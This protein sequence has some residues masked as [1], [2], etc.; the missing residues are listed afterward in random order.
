MRRVA[1]VCAVGMLGVGFAGCPASR[2]SGWK[3][4]PYPDAHDFA[5]T[6]VH[7]ADSAYSQRLA[8]LLDT[9]DA[10]DMKVTLTVFAFWAD[11]ASDGK[12]WDEWRSGSDTQ[13][14]LAP[15]GVPLV[16][17]DEAAFY[18]HAAARG[19]E[20]GL[21]T[22]SDTSDTREDVKRAFELYE[23]VFGHPLRMYVEHSQSSNL[24]DQFHD[25]SKPG[26]PYYCTDLLKQYGPWVWLDGPTG[27]PPERQPFY[28]LLAANGTPFDETAVERFGISRAFVRSGRWSDADGSGFLESYSVDNIDAL[29][30]ERGVALVYTHLDDRWLDPQTRKTREDIVQRLKYLASKDGWFVPAGA[31]LDRF[32]AMKSVTL[33]SAGTVVSIHNAG[34]ASVP[35]VTIINPRKQTLYRGSEALVA[36]AQGELVIGTLEPGQTLSLSTQP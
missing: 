34:P 3:L 33:I 17:A 9:F 6:L 22:P 10:L 27:L 5:W 13:R 32:E 19:H 2:S 31:I 15:V 30:R 4:S 14:W 35:G 24:E 16:D 23:Q 21:H 25:G 20:I 8:P 18:L 11:W 7:D 12:V 28:D 36:N 26:S 29:A 1:W